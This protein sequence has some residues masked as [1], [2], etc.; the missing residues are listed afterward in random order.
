MPTGRGGGDS[1]NLGDV[2]TPSG[3]GGADVSSEQAG[4]S[5]VRWRFHA[6]RLCR[7]R[8]EEVRGIGRIRYRK[9][10]RRREQQQ[11]VGRRR[12][13]RAGVHGNPLP[14]LPKQPRR[15]PPRTPIRLSHRSNLRRHRLHRLLPLPRA[16]LRLVL[17]RRQHSL[18]R[19]VLLPVQFGIRRRMRGRRAQ[20][21]PTR[22]YHDRAGCQTGGRSVSRRGR[23]EEHS[24]HVGVGGRG[25]SFDDW[26]DRFGRGGDRGGCGGRGRLG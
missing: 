1:R 21:R 19:L 5:G 13:R 25:E 6:E 17:Q 20:G 26:C 24:R 4:C 23:G 12:R 14:R 7:G 16:H 9:K 22:R 18:R 3:R 15:L 8:M 2:G 11:T 10:G